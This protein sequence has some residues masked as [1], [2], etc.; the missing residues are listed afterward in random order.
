GW[1]RQDS[2]TTTR[3]PLDL[4]RNTRD[5]ARSGVDPR[6]N[7]LIHLQ[8]GDVGGSSG[9]LTAGAYEYAVPNGGYQVTVSVGDQPAY[10]SP[11]TVRVEGGPAIRAFVL[12]P[13]AAGLAATPGDPQV[14]LAW[15]AD[16]SATGYRLYR[17]G[18][19]IAAPAQN[20]H[21]DV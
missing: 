16:A 15:T 19:L 17:G 2:L 21:V 4:T 9:V 18:I 6:L 5:R 10:D 1:V 13:A 12:T 8:Y 20:S 14:A 11:H 7:T 3:V